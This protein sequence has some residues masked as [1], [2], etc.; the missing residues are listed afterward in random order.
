MPI[1][2]TLHLLAA[3]IWIGGMFFAYMIL[4][5]CAAQQLPPP[6]RIILWH[7]C[8]KRF[9]PWVWGSIII[10]IGTGYSMTLIL[11]DGVNN[12]GW[13]IKAMGINGLL[14]TSLFAYLYLHPYTQFKRLVAK[15][16]YPEAGQA[17]ASIRTIIGINLIIGLLTTITATMGDI[18]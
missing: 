10:L 11:F 1:T 14:M 17:L 3:I 16:R 7:D 8:F 6:Q 2:I 4:R 13:H 5:P 9:F 18:R 12:S 15:E